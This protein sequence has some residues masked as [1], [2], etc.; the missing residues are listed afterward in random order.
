MSE[1]EGK[2]EHMLVLSSSELDPIRTDRNVRFGACLYQ[3]Q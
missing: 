1:F 2:A 3:G